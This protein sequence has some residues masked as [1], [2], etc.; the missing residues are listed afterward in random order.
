MGLKDE[1][2]D[3][4]WVWTETDET[5]TF[6]DWGGSE[7]NGG[8]SENCAMFAHWLNY[9]WNDSPCTANYIPLCEI[10][11]VLSSAFCHLS[12]FGQKKKNHQAT[13]FIIKQLF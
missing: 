2:A 11:L 1:I 6:T 3:G 5:A 9:T 4:T 13:S 7:P 10:S 8:Q 12:L